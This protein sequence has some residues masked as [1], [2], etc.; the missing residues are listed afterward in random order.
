MAMEIIGKERKQ[1]RWKGFDNCLGMGINDASGGA[2]AAAAAPAPAVSSKS[3]GDGSSLA[4]ER[5]IAIA[6]RSIRDRRHA[7]DLKKKDLDSLALQYVACNSLIA[8]NGRSVG[9]HQSCPEDEKIRLPFTLLE[10]EDTH[11]AEVMKD[12]ENTTVL[13]EFGS[14]RPIF[15]NAEWIMQQTGEA[16]M[17]RLA[18]SAAAPSSHSSS[19]ATMELEPL[20]SNGA[21]EEDDSPQPPRATQSNASAPDTTDE[22]FNALV[23]LAA[24]SAASPKLKPYASRRSAAAAAS[25]SASASRASLAA[26]S[27]VATAAPAHP[28]SILD[29]MVFSLLPASSVLRAE[30]PA[31]V[32]PQPVA[33]SGRKNSRAAAPQHAAPSRSASGRAT[34]SA[35]KAAAASS[36]PASS[37][38]YHASIPPSGAA[39]SSLGA[40]ATAASTAPSHTLGSVLLGYGA[41]LGR[42]TLPSPAGLAATSLSSP[43]KLELSSSGGMASTGA[44][45]GTTM[46]L[47]A[48][49]RASS[50]GGHTQTQMHSRGVSNTSAWESVTPPPI[51]AAAATSDGSAKMES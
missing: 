14:S 11:P 35:S 36:A 49:G 46:P 22:S 2:A 48:G 18:E 8:R 24:A 34:G 10:A 20:Y 30:I 3:N 40:A 5:E 23:S 29:P 31:A 41:G 45:L 43:V 47:S 17:R 1:I 38:H 32:A 19:P 37:P 44:P 7:I 42:T 28:R 26:S 51:A 39:L 15:H 9:A 12:E 13:I 16:Y 6:Q 21:T 4:S 33:T 25:G 50:A 27:S